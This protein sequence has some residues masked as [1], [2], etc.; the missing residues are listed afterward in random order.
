[1]RSRYAV[2]ALLPILLCIL[3][4]GQQHVSSG[5]SNDPIV[6]KWVLSAGKST[7]PPRDST[8]TIEATRNR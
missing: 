8:I 5:T 6:G 4:S 7:L 2:S 1:M 3:E